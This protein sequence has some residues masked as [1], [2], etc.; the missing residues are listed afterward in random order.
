VALSVDDFFLAR[1]D[2]PK[3]EEGRYDFE[4][5]EAINLELFN[6]SLAALLERGEAKV[7]RYDFRLGKPTPRDTWVTQQ[8]APYEVL[9]IEGIHALNPKLTPVVPNQ[10]KFH[11]FISAITQLSIDYHNRIFTSDGRLLRRIVRDRRYRGYS[12]AQTL[13]R[14]P[15]VRR[16]EMRHIFP[17]EE[18]ADALF[19][20]ALVYEHA[21]LR[22]YV[23]RYLLEIDEHHDAFQEAYRLLGYLR[24]VVPILPD[25]VPQNSILREFI[26]N[27]AFHSSH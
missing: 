1:E 25:A 16:G 6:E 15:L 4:C 22:N 8:L 18:R 24:R 17:F 21:V 5:L 20:S 26:G 27:S 14:W 3:D 12:A 9:L 2:T 10:R 7:P 23:Q 19:N 13:T 11:I